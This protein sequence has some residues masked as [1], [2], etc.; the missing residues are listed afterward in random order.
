MKFFL[1]AIAISALLFIQYGCSSGKYATTN[2]SYKKQVRS[3]AK[4]LN[5]YPLQDSAG[6]PYADPWV[7]TT[8]MSIR[9]ANYV[10]IHHTAQNSCEQTLLTFTLPRTQVSAHYVICKDGTVHHMLNDLLRAHHAG[11]S[12]WGNTTDLNSSSIGIEIDNNG[13]EPFT[14]QQITS[15]LTLLGRLKRAYTI[16]TA[17][18]IGHAD[19]APGRK[20]DPNRFFP[21][22]KLAQNGYG[23]WYDTAG[24]KPPADFN[25]MQALRIVGYDIK[26]PGNAIQSFKIH[27]V[28]QDTTKV[29]TE[30]D[31]KILFD[32]EKKYQ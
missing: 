16:P 21:W 32:L 29:I 20:V 28:Q 27:F 7:G 22:Q 8:N 24:V 31:R 17:N 13:F 19:V 25:A 18:F 6:L 23:F 30:E 1:S 5:E 14:E 11:V 15:L 3:F 2:K 4:L 10:V 12:R 26:N 9:R